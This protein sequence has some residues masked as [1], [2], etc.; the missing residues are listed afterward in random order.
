[1]PGA[2]ELT[3]FSGDPDLSSAFLGHHRDRIAKLTRLVRRERAR[4]LDREANVRL[5]TEAATAPTGSGAL[6][7]EL[8][9]LDRR[10]TKQRREAEAMIDSLLKLGRMQKDMQD[11]ERREAEKQKRENEERRMQDDRHI[12][13][14]REMGDMEQRR[15][16]DE[17]DQH[18]AAEATRRGKAAADA[19]EG[20]VA[21]RAGGGESP[22]P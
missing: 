1:M 8:R 20:A 14:L 13:R 18:R 5:P 6:E 9:Q 10:R 7:M 17:E 22:G 11:A 2:R 12:Q 3:R 19:G 15:L 4:V 21:D 16:K